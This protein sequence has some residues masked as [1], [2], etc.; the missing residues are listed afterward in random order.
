MTRLTKFLGKLLLGAARDRSGTISVL[1]ALSLTA[2]LGFAGLGTEV[3]YWYV[4]TR[5]MQSAADSAA[6]TAA[7]AMKN[8]ETFS[9]GTP[10]ADARAVAAT[11]GYYDHVNNVNVDVHNPPNSGPYA[12]NSSAIEVIVN[13]TP[14]RLISALFMNSSPTI[15]GRAVAA[16][17]GGGVAPC[18][19]ALNTGNITTA[20][21]GTPVVNIP[22]CDMYINSSDPTNAL[23][24]QGHAT[25]NAHSTYVNG[26]IN[27]SGGGV[28][29][30]SSGTYANTGTTKPDPFAS[31]NF[32]MPSGCDQTNYSAPTS[33]TT[34]IDPGVYCGGIVVNSGA[35]LHLDPGV[36]YMNGGTGTNNV[37]FQLNG[38]GTITGDG[39]TIVLTGSGSNY[40]TVQIN[41]NSTLTLDEGTP[42]PIGGLAFFQDRNAPVTP[43]IPTGTTQ[44]TF[45]GGANMN[46]NGG[47]YFPNQLV[48]YSGG[49]ATGGAECT[50]L[51]SNFIAISGNTNFSGNCSTVTGGAGGGTPTVALVE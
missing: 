37:G 34:T 8:G 16:V 30:D 36:Y 19:M 40:A 22:S 42:G 27:T 5:N 6:M 46:I 1:T 13:D 10:Q 12:G 25:I 23:D 32:S 48:T 4:K 15:G 3:S 33:A 35:T 7:E 47:I 31:D 39:V 20:V 11:Y 21:S 38:G 51:V 50:Q 29:N 43:A 18:I 14:P 24:V 28:L 44:N 41:G 2:V 49:A 45:N 9:S 17:T 26:G